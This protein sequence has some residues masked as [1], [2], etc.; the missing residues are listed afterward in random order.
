MPEDSLHLNCVEHSGVRVRLAIILGLLVSCVGGIMTLITM[1]A[2]IYVGMN[3]NLAE[4]SR[5]VA[6]NSKRIEVI[7]SRQETDTKR[8]MALEISYHS[9]PP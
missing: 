3:A 7:E 6:V 8:I 2:S 1:T 9:S 5:T 4:L